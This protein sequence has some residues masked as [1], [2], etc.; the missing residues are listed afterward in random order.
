MT[1]E[2]E[3]FR[4]RLR[5]VLVFPVTPFRQDLSLDLEGLAT[6]LAALAEHP[7]AALVAAGGTGEVYSLTPAEQKDVL[8]S[9]YEAIGQA[10]PR[11][12]VVY[13]RDWVQPAPAW[14]E[15][16]A[17]RVPTLVAW[18]DGQGDLRRLA[19]V[20]A[21]VGERLA[22]VGGADDDCAPGY[23]AIGL[24]AAAD[25]ALLWPGRTGVDFEAR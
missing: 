16:L 9:Y 20:P 14:V 21:R 19:Q 22:W 7:F 25:R 6:N 3:G 13:G 4:S 5:G 11:A 15:R 12:L 2:L 18:K 10:S 1:S 8:L 24:R 23:Y 17:E